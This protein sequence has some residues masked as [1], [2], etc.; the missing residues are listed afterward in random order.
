MKF[1]AALTGFNSRQFKTRMKKMAAQVEFCLIL[2]VF[3]RACNSMPE[4]DHLCTNKGHNNFLTS[5]LASSKNIN[6]GK[7]LRANT[8]F[9]IFLATTSC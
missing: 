1:D 6:V 5:L 2:N 4:N 9:S 3:C 8:F 7:S